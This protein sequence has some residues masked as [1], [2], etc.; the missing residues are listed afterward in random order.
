MA[1][2]LLGSMSACSFRDSLDE[3]GLYL[4]FTYDYN[5]AYADASA[6]EIDRIDVLVFDAD[7]V[8][9]F[10]KTADR[11]YLDSAGYTLSFTQELS[12]GSYTFLTWSGLSDDF[13][14]QDVRAR[15]SELIA[16]QTRMD[17]I[18]LQMAHDSNGSVT[19]Q[20]H[21]VWYGAPQ[22]ITYDPRKGLQT[23]PVRLVKDTNHFSIALS[24][25]NS[26]GGG[27]GELLVYTFE[28][29]SKGYDLYDM[30]NK[31]VGQAELSFLP[32]SI[33]SD[34]D[35]AQT[36]GKLTTGRLLEEDTQT[37]VIRSAH[38]NSLLWQTDLIGLLA[39][40][41]PEDIGTVQEYLDRQ[42]DWSLVFNYKGGTGGTGGSGFVAVSV[43]INGWTIWLQDIDM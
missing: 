20:L 30:N 14:L 11:D 21:P 22:R 13:R 32:Y 36:W 17:D 31:P 5:M 18:R 3:C 39:R 34:G 26:S 42:D 33:S 10:T 15:S 16:G 25:D 6:R 43:V 38:D 23:C 28:I 19:S 40:T 12:F 35:Y 1:V 7:G 41:K 27:A 9:L 24:E 8:Y 37:L 2:M 29:I 4:H